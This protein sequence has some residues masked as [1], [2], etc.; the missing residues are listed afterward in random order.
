MEFMENILNGMGHPRLLKYNEC[1][2]MVLVEQLKV[3]S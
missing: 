1:F 3:Q 2:E